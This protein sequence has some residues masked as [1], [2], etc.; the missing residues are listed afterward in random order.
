VD[1]VGKKDNPEVQEDM[2]KAHMDCKRRL[3]TH[4][5]HYYG[6]DFN[7]NVLTIG[8]A[9]RAASY[10]RAD[11]L[12]SDISRLKALA[13][14]N[15]G[16]QLVFSGKAHYQDANGISIIEKILKLK[17]SGELDGTGIKIAFIE[18]YDMEVGEMITSGSDVWLN[19]PQ[20]PR[21]A[22]GTSGMKAAMSGVLNLSTR[23]GW[24]YEERSGGLGGWSIGPR[25]ESGFKQ[26]LDEPLNNIDAE[27]LYNVLGHQVMPQ[28]RRA[29][30]DHSDAARA[31]WISRMIA[32]IGHNGA[33]F[34]GSRM[35][36]EYVEQHYSHFLAA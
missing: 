17:E 4:I 28:W 25:I 32:T 23:D 8:F 35:M 6:Q 18:D 29:F 22:S 26:A 27:D 3:L 30:I 14:A 16:L 12:F 31:E 36:Q 9:R 1:L 20:A 24:W 2:W 19:N 10:K 33:Y 15:G 5:L 21:E 34:S 7:E 11:L 13:S